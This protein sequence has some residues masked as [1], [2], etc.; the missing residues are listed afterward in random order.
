MFFFK[1]IFERIGVEFVYVCCYKMDEDNVK[2]KK[3]DEDDECGLFGV[4]WVRQK[5][6]ILEYR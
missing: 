1:V 2:K 4:R 3:M 6:V 5:V